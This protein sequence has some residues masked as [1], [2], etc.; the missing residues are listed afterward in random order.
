MKSS[1]GRNGL[2]ALVAVVAVYLIS[3]T[4]M[5]LSVYVLLSVAVARIYELRYYMM[6]PACDY[7]GKNRDDIASR[8]GSID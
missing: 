7:D 3:S 6:L 1:L 5:L 8:L 2:D 4:M